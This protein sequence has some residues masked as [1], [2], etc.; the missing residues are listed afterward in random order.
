MRGRIRC[1]KH[2]LL[3]LSVRPPRQQSNLLCRLIPRYRVD[4]S[5]SIIS[6]KW[7]T[8]LSRHGVVMADAS[9]P[10]D[11]FSRIEQVYRQALD[12]A[13]EERPV[14]LAQACVGDDDLRREVEKLLSFDKKAGSFM[15]SPALD[16]AAQALGL[17][18]LSVD[19]L[20]DR[21]LTTAP[22]GSF[23]T[24]PAF[25]PDSRTLA[26]TRSGSGDKR[27]WFLK[28]GKNCEPQGKPQTS[29]LSIER[30]K[31]DNLGAAWTPDGRDI[32]FWSGDYG[33]HLVCWSGG[34]LRRMSASVPWHPVRLAFGSDVP[35]V[36][37]I[38]PHGNRLAYAQHVASSV[39]QPRR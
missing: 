20:E 32:V 30:D 22:A 7:S 17:L 24:M 19:T 38:S 31:H 37:A 4:L 8:Q 26:F 3:P 6:G 23:D 15:E 12:R 25:S 14:F 10:K 27:I 34:G 13:E 16:V 33:D 18:L 1:V 36:P 35:S 11:R 21:R 9:R 5:R 29:A 39:P 28:T 2:P